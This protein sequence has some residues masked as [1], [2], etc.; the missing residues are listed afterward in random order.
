VTTVSIVTPSFNQAE[1]LP[2]CIESVC[3]QSHPI[4]E[5]FVFDPGS[6]DGSR[7]VAAAYP[8]V[9]LVAE[10]DD[11]QADAVGRGMKRSS[12]DIV[13][14]LNS[15]DIYIDS[16]VVARVIARFAEP[17]A[18]DLVYGQGQYI[19]EAGNRIKDAYVNA[20]PATLPV[21]LHHEVG[22]LQ[23]TVFFRR[24]VF[25]RIGYPR[26][27]LNFAMDYDLWI[28]AVKARLRIAH[29][30]TPLAGAR[31]YPDNKTMG[32]RGASYQEVLSLT[33]QHFGATHVRWARRLADFRINDLD[34]V[35]RA[36]TGSSTLVEQ[37]TARVLQA[38]TCGWHARRTL[39]T[40]RAIEPYRETYD[41]LETHGLLTSR[42]AAPADEW[43]DHT[44]P[45]FDIHGQVWRFDPEWHA[46]VTRTS[47]ITLSTFADT[48]SDA[49][50]VVLAGNGSIHGFPHSTSLDLIVVD[51]HLSTTDGLDRCSAV[52]VGDPLVLEQSAALL[53]L[54]ADRTVLAP[55]WASYVLHPG[56]HRLLVSDE[57]CTRAKLPIEQSEPGLR[58]LILALVLAAHRGY[59]RVVVVGRDTQQITTLRDWL[60]A[61]LVQSYALHSYSEQTWNDVLST[62]G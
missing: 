58:G 15:D 61:E 17:D 1:Y 62:I 42:V 2:A 3:G 60:P 5:H 20:D 50:C 4:A 28:R 40:N 24:S 33:T 23:P 59:R 41:F 37:E 29:I 18:P 25:D 49:D 35:L 26:T 6:S 22:I 46:S 44:A 54:I 11:G 45:S 43:P 30:P 47:E 39:E 48:R 36:P 16:E 10:P 52:T 53:N 7:D 12:S 51:R 34:G 9:T 14:W 13:G 8:S 38:Y 56:P 27:D 55:W 21:S 57:T 32:Q 31:Y 19:N